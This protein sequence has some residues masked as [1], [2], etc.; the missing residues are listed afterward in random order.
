MRS[1]TTWRWRVLTVTTLLAATVVAPHSVERLAAQEPTLE[2]VLER[3][4]AYVAAYQL[5]LS[6]LV[7]E[8]RYLQSADGEERRLLSEL[9]VF[10]TPGS[11]EP[12]VTFRDVLEVDGLKVEGREQRLTEM[13]ADTTYV[14]SGVRRRL[15]AESARY[16]IGAIQRNLNVPTMALLLLDAK[17]QPRVEFSKDG[18]DDI[19][20]V[21]VWEIEYE[22]REPPALIRNPGERDLFAKGSFWIEPSSGR[23]FQTTLSARDRSVNLELDFTVRYEM[24]E[25]LGM[26]VP[27]RM[28]ERYVVNLPQM[29]SSRFQ[30]AQ[31]NVEC[32]ANYSNYRRFGVQT[33]TTTSAPAPK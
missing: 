26:L 1:S 28:T 14:T 32:V 29:S 19:D 25:R 4:A 9:L 31:I 17:D 11:R 8:E 13:F 23:V 33:E 22:E 16:N 5:E 18:E 3:A 2:V 15:V 6:N 27:A 21:E 12:W 24:A 20:G 7:A 30:R 10:S